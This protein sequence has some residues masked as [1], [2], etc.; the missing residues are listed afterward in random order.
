MGYQVSHVCS[1][2]GNIIVLC[3]L[4]LIYFWIASWKTIFIRKMEIK[5]K[6]AILRAFDFNYSF[7]VIEN[8]D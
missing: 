8:H 3:T 5:F 7:E 2:A 6:V 1:V 4:I